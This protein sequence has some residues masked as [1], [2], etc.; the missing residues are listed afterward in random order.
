MPLA[1]AD[2]SL[3]STSD[4]DSDS[5]WD[6]YSVGPA[7]AG[8]GPLHR[9]SPERSSGTLGALGGWATP[10]RPVGR[11]FSARLRADSLLSPFSRRLATPTK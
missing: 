9:L 4:S 8:G 5:D 2:S 1:P 3:P 11:A 7:A 10:D 6:R